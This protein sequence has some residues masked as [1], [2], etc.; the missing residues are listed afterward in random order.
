MCK[1]LSDTE[2]HFVH[3]LLYLPAFT[4]DFNIDSGETD[5]IETDMLEHLI[6]V[7]PFDGKTHHHIRGCSKHQQ[8]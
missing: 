6:L 4:H 3:P 2:Q 8:L 1:H 7:H 5:Y